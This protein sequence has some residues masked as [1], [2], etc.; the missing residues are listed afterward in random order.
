MR[1]WIYSL[2]ILVTTLGVWSVG[3]WYVSQER[4]QFAETTIQTQSTLLD[5]SIEKSTV[6]SSQNEILLDEFDDLKRELRKEQGRFNDLEDQVGD[7]LETVE[8]LKR[9]S[10][11][12]EELLM[13]YS[14]VY[15]LNEH[16]QPNT[17]E[18]IDEDFLWGDRQL[19][20]AG[21]V[22]PF[23]EELLEDAQDDDID[24]RILSAYRS[25]QT[26]SQ[27]KDQYVQTFGTTVANTFS[28]DQG[29]SEHQLGTTVD[30]TTPEGGTNLSTFA[31]SDAYDWLQ[32]NAYKYGFILSYPEGNSYYV[33][34]PWHWRFVGK[35]LARKLDRSDESFYDLEQREINEYIV[36]LFED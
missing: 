22:E 6:L 2:S 4:E 18:D 25:F 14:R 31:G 34:E 33:Y 32:D 29:Y 28:A 10:E 5:F 36:N 8:I 35:E 24:L 13:K 20:I 23:L 16:Y 1:Y 19:Q 11:T 9:I 30:F 17:L 15:F 7:S 12:D 27:I 3:Q 21:Q 26:Q